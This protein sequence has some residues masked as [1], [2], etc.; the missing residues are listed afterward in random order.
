MRREGLC[1][2]VRGRKKRT[3]FP[4]DAAR[5]PLDLVK[6][7][8]AAPRPDKLCIAEFTYVATWMG[9]VYVRDSRLASE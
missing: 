7:Q 2:A 1:L 6:R 3:T 4:A 5:R 8:L 9:F